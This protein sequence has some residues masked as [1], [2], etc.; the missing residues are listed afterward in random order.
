MFHHADPVVQVVL[1]GLLAASVVTWTVLVA[2]GLSFLAARRSVRLAL[3]RAEN[4]RTLGRIAGA[5]ARR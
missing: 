2:K 4:Q 1:V 3:G 5:V